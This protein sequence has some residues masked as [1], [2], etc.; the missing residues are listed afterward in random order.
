MKIVK[1]FLASLILLSFACSSDDDSTTNSLID[2]DLLIGTWQL[3]ASVS[4]GEII[5]L[6]ECD[7]QNTLEFT[8]T[9]AL[10]ATVNNSSVT[11]DGSLIC[12]ASLTLTLDYT[13]QGNLLTIQTGTDANI[14]TIVTLTET[15]LILEFSY[16]ETDGTDTVLVTDRETYERR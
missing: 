14:G 7:L 4:N 1:F 2:G 12:Q 11:I 13:L 3:T 15:T 5:E 6:D 10:N 8:E 9:G 16:E